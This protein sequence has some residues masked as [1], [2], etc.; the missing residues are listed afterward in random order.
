MSN[1]FSISPI[2]FQLYQEDRKDVVYYRY[3]ALHT[4]T[5]SLAL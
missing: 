2:L 3:V 1:Q 4:P 5:Y